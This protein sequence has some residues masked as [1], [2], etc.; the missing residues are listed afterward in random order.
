VK[1]NDNQWAALTSW[2]FNNGCG[3][4]KSS[5]LVKRLNNGENPNTVAAQELPKWRMAGGKVLSG[6]VRRRAAEV[7]LFQTPSSKEA[8]PNCQ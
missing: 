6:L 2:V 5:E 7:K 1:L 4:A 8:F 3:A